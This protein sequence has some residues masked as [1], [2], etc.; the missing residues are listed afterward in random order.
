MQIPSFIQDRLSQFWLLL[1]VLFLVTGVF[2]GTDYPV[3]YIYFALGIACVFWGFCIVVLRPRKPEYSWTEP[4]SVADQNPV[5]DQS[6]VA[7]QSPSADEEEPLKQS[8]AK[9]VMEPMVELADLP[10]LEDLPDAP[11][12]NS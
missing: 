7:D 2:L 1:G 5:T 10:G 12:E 11:E 3:T 6:P 8:M 4:A 9:P